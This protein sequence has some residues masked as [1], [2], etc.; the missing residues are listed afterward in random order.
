MPSIE[1]SQRNRLLALFGP[2]NVMRASELKD[3]G[4]TPA[5]IARAVEDGEIERVSRGLYQRCRV[6][7]ARHHALAVA[8]MRVPKGIVTMV[9][10]LAFHGLVDEEHPRVW[11]ALG[12]HDWAPGPSCPPLRILR[13]AEPYLRQ[14][15]EHHAIGGVNVPVYGLAKTLADVFRHPRLVARATAVE[16]LRRAVRERKVSL[17]ALE[18]NARAGSVW[19]IMRPYLDSALLRA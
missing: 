8:S 17:E 10:A 13:F 16:A 14:G 4:I 2:R 18:R 19:T 1:H 12:P 5:A 15:V 7:V 3:A 6:D 9:S 11:M